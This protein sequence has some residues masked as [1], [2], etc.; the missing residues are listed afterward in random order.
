MESQ[1]N[2]KPNATPIAVVG[3]VGEEFDKT[4]DKSNSLPIS[5]YYIYSKGLRVN[6]DTK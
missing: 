3:K 6:P 4:E 1:K 5:D 2:E